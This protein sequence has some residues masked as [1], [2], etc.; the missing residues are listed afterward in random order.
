MIPTDEYRDTGW[1][2]VG[3][4]S[5]R[6]TPSRVRQYSVVRTYF[7]GRRPARFLSSTSLPPLSLVHLLTLSVPY[8]LLSSSLRTLRRL[9]SPTSSSSTPGV[10]TVKAVAAGPVLPGGSRDPH[11]CCPADDLGPG[12]D[13]RTS[14]TSG[15]H[16]ASQDL[17]LPGRRTGSPTARL[18][19]RSTGQERP[20]SRAPGGLPLSVESLLHAEV[21]L[22]PAPPAC[23]ERVAVLYELPLQPDSR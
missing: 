14:K 6:L 5:N 2:G 21:L 12:S 15:T 4:D 11:L 7:P 8:V 16:G 22:V 17:R 23:V 13:L 1:R 9:L 10:G 20:P 18:P 3:P 19:A